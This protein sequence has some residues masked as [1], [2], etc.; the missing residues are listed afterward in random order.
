LHVLFV[1]RRDQREM[2]ARLLSPA[3][4]ELLAI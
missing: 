2:L 4:F 1:V 3:E